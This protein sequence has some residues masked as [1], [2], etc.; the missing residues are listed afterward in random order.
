MPDCGTMIPTLIVRSGT[1]PAPAGAWLPL[2]LGAPLLPAPPR[3]Q[4]ASAAA[5]SVPSASCPK[6][7]RV[8]RRVAR[9]MVSPL[10][11]P[12]PWWLLR[13]CPVTRDPSGPPPPRQGAPAVHGGRYSGPGPLALVEAPHAHP[14]QDIRLVLLAQVGALP[15]L[16]DLVLRPRRV[17]LVRE[18]A[19]EQQA[20]ARSQPLDSVAQALLAPLAA[21]EQ[22]ARLDVVAGRPPHPPA[23]LAALASRPSVIGPVEPVHH[24]RHPARAR[25]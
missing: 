20:L 15:Q 1:Q 25:L 22:V 6:V 8:M 12:G 17:R 7:R 9:L 16:G 19:S 14:A 2:G 24:E 18:V 4:P 10:A 23:V 3:A 13:Y 21:K 11:N 5:P